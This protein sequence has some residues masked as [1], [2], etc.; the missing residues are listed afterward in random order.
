VYD[1]AEKARKQKPAAQVPEG[2]VGEARPGDFPR[3]RTTGTKRAKEAGGS[4]DRSKFDWSSARCSQRDWEAMLRRGH[5]PEMAAAAAD[6]LSAQGE[7][8]FL[9]RYQIC[10]DIR[11]QWKEHCSDNP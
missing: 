10:H 1:K 8:T 5:A 9:N 7:I 6:S 3:S 2:I 4:V 11:S